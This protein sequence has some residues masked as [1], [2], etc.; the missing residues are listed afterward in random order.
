MKLVYSFPVLLLL[1]YGVCFGQGVILKGRVTYKGTG[2]DKIQLSLDPPADNMG[3]RFLNEQKTQISDK[4]GYFT[5]E[6]SNEL[7]Q[8]AGATIRVFI[9]LGSRRKS[10]I[11]IHIS[12]PYVMCVDDRVIFENSLGVP[13]L[14]FTFDRSDKIQ[15]LPV[16]ELC[17]EGRNK[18]IRK[19]EAGVAEAIKVLKDT[20][21]QDEKTN[22]PELF[23]QELD[24]SKKKLNNQYV[25]VS[26][27]ETIRTLN[28]KVDSLQQILNFIYDKPSDSLPVLGTINKIDS[29]E[30]LIQRCKEDLIKC[31]QKQNHNTASSS[32]DNIANKL[33]LISRDTIHFE[34]NNSMLTDISKKILDS[35]L[36]KTKDSSIIAISAHTDEDGSAEFNFQLSVARGNAIKL[37]FI[38]KGVDFRRI[39]VSAM[40]KNSLLNN[41]GTSRD[42]LINRRAEIIIYNPQY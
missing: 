41:G 14:K 38:N 15:E 25:T 3:K 5:F 28:I 34:V 21:N 18:I 33:N 20:I 32:L 23:P 8:V 9:F 4:G 27:E 30:N 24:S 35:L 37:Y 17:R 16:I 6:L 11:D 10:P 29:L 39:N 31:Q 2:M 1:L 42:K 12:K 36:I 7:E 26:S 22:D 13:F 40:S 19:Y